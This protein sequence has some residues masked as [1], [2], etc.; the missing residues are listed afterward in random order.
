MGHP[1]CHNGF[2]NRDVFADQIHP[3][4][5]HKTLARSLAADGGVLDNLCRMGRMGVVRPTKL[6]ALWPYDH[7]N[8]PFVGRCRATTYSRHL[9]TWRILG[10]ECEQIGMMPCT[11]PF[12]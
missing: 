1:E 12:S 5:T 8:L 2:G 9:R 3:S 4:N 6:G 7:I 11:S 10:K